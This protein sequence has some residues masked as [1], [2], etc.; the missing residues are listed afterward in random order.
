M[1]VN[2]LRIMLPQ[3]K[4]VKADSNSKKTINLKSQPSS[5][6]RFLLGLNNKVSDMDKRLK[7]LETTTDHLLRFSVGYKELALTFVLAL[8]TFTSITLALREFQ[9]N[10]SINTEYLLKHPELIKQLLSQSQYAQS[11]TNTPTSDARFTTQS[12]F[13]W[14]LERQPNINDIDYISHKHGIEL[15]AK[16]GDPIVAIDHG[17]VLYSG[18]AINS[19]GNLILIQHSND[20]ISVYGNNYSNYVAE[21]ETIKK[22][23]L[24]AAVGEGNGKQPR[25]YFEVRYKGKAQDPFNYFKE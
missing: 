18:D 4:L 21:G 7:R 16:L 10:S 1:N 19:Y 6:A 9:P 14:P 5:R 13:K 24:I 11:N 12:Q 15:N 3:P 20:I 8:L 23:Q 25:L 17:K 22:G 2:E